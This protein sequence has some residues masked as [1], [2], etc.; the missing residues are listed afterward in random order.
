MASVVQVTAQADNHDMWPLFTDI[1][2]TK[3]IHRYMCC[4]IAFFIKQIQG[5]NQQGKDIHYARCMQMQQQHRRATCWSC[6]TLK[7]VNSLH[8]QF[9][10][11]CC[12]KAPLQDCADLPH[13]RHAMVTA[14][15]HMDKYMGILEFRV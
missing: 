9:A 4:D 15:T 3:A 10:D 8:I 5:R 6:R 7:A 2:S 12:G 1:V 13:L 14:S 11:C